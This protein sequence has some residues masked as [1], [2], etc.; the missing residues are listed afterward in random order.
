MTTPE[1][2]AAPPQDPSE[3]TPAERLQRR[4]VQDVKA[5]EVDPP[6]PDRTPHD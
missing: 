5:Y 3:P 1:P 4:L 6:A 2:D